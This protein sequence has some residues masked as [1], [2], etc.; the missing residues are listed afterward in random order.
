MIKFL[1]CALILVLSGCEQ[2]EDVIVDSTHKGPVGRLVKYVNL[3]ENESIDLIRKVENI[4]PK[5]VKDAI[6]KTT[7]K[8]EIVAGDANAFMKYMKGKDI[9]FTDYDYKG[10]AGYGFEPKTIVYSILDEYV[11]IHE[12]A[13]AYEYSFWYDGTK[14][15]PSSS[16]K[17]KEA[18]KSEYIS[19]LG[20]KNVMEFYAECF[21][22]YFRNPKMLEKLCPMAY[23]L[24]DREFKN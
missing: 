6:Y 22:M 9:E 14:D 24:L 23:E 16:W 4:L 21:A 10:I 1:I 2:H 17:W 8:I 5:K 19:K 11:L 3:T 18:Y 20:Q 13:H 12:L 7:N 15:N